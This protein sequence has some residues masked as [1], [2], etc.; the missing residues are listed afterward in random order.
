M[1]IAFFS[2]AQQRRRR[3]WP[4]RYAAAIRGQEDLYARCPL[5]RQTV[6]EAPRLLSDLDSALIRRAPP[7][8]FLVLRRGRWKRQPR[9]GPGKYELILDAGELVANGF[10]M[11]LSAYRWDALGCVE[12]LLRLLGSTLAC[13]CAGGSMAA[14]V[15]AEPSDYLVNFF[16]AFEVDVRLLGSS[17]RPVIIATAKEAI[18]TEQIESVV[19]RE[20]AEERSHGRYASILRAALAGERPL[21]LLDVG[22]GDGHMAEW[23]SDMGCD[24]HLLEV[25][26]DCAVAATARLGQ[27]RVALHD[28]VSAW[29]YPESSFDVCLLLFVLHHIGEE[30]ALEHTLAEAARVSRRVLVLEDQPRHS[31]SA[32]LGRLAVA[33]TA[34]HFRPFG[35]D[36][37]QYLR[38]IR[39]DSTW[40]MLFQQAGLQLQRAVEIPGTL[41]HPVPHTFYELCVFIELANGKGSKQVFRSSI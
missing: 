36:P 40:R 1:A 13:L 23:W 10:V 12:T 32:G 2:S 20:V 5:V 27:E 25:D 39:P 28:G 11:Q 22:G 38:N 26:A 35:Q 7:C 14:M 6:D 17:S 21:R 19:R 31:A 29:P 16:R 41:Q 18:T 8:S 15:S 9:P 24:V 33:V 34:E 4:D 37:A 30:K 3:R